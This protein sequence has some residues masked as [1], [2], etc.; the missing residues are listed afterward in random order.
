MKKEKT[1]D[2]K[3][4]KWLTDE[5][6]Q[7]KYKKRQACKGGREHDWVMCLPHG[8]EATPDYKGHPEACYEMEEAIEKHAEKLAEEL[9]KTEGI[10]STYGRSTFRNYRMKMRQ[11]CC[12]VCFKQKYESI[13]EPK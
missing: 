13:R 2:S 3:S 8:F 12:S 5:E 6:Y 11:Y 4:K 7:R 10:K 1:Y 9:E